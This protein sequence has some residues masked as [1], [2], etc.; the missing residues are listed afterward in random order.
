M[1]SHKVQGHATRPR[2]NQENVNVKLKDITA[3]NFSHFQPTR[4]P[5]LDDLA[6]KLSNKHVLPGKLMGPSAVVVKKAVLPQNNAKIKKDKEN[7]IQLTKNVGVKENVA[8]KKTHVEV[9]PKSIREPEKIPIGPSKTLNKKCKELLI[10]DSDEE[11]RRDP[12]MVS[13]YVE[14]IL[15]YLRGIEHTYP[16]KEKFLA[17]TKVSPKMRSMLVNWLVEVH[18]NF[19]MCQETLFLAVSL[20]DRYSQENHG[21]D[22]KIYQLVGTASLLLASKYEDIYIPDL[23]DFVFICDEAFTKRQILQMEVDIMRRLDFRMGWPISI[24]FL[25][26]YSKVANAKPEHHTLAK[27]L[28]ELAMLEYDV[29]HV[30]P[31]VQAAAACCL[32]I[33]ILNETMDPSRV[34]NA[35]LAR[36]ATYKYADFADV[37]VALAR[38]V[39]K[40][41]TSKFDVVKIKYAASQYGKVSTNFK[42]KGP[43]IRKL[44]LG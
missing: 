7:A 3:N 18:N 43:L 34:W 8:K 15:A 9:I 21:V 19:K 29:S 13:E 40:A 38:C 39:V 20:C 32:S 31:S 37:V 41:E 36:H 2:E 33:A 27:Y 16:I 10:N 42:L 1:A 24:F 22:A 23:D 17:D 28:L 4:R 44:T 5:A 26:R 25:R 11:S 35:T 6:N 14:D 30:K 12:Q